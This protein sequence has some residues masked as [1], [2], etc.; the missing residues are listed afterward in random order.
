MRR[1]HPAHLDFLLIR[2]SPPLVNVGRL[3]NGTDNLMIERAEIIG[4]ADQFFAEGAGNSASVIAALEKYARDGRY[5]NALE[6]LIHEFVETPSHELPT[7]DAS[8][9]VLELGGNWSLLLAN[10]GAP[11]QQLYSQ[12]FRGFICPINHPITISRYRFPHGW[13]P[14]VFELET[15]VELCATEVIQPLSACYFDG[16]SELV[17]L[18]ISAESTAVLKLFEVPTAPM[19]WA[20]DR[21]SLG[22]TGVIAADP[23]ATR[24]QYIVKV[25]GEMASETSIPHVESACRDDMHFVRWAAVQ[26]LGKLSGEKALA[27]LEEMSQQ[28]PQM[29]IRSAARAAINN[30]VRG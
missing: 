22:A 16:H 2:D 21:A 13:R 20:F 6:S 18:A 1:D 19:E 25:L 14:D 9:V 4:H 24:R 17:D 15:K 23:S 7:V 26:A 30:S 3:S 11:T 29:A 8:R 10:Q 28:D 12:P 5:L 27:V